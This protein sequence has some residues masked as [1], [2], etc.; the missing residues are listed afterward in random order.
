MQPADA[1]LKSVL[2]RYRN[3]SL[4]LNR[5]TS[6]DEWQKGEE[7][8]TKTKTALSLHFYEPIKGKL[9]ENVPLW[10]YLKGLSPLPIIRYGEEENLPLLPTQFVVTHLENHLKNEEWEAWNEKE[11][12]EFVEIGTI[13]SRILK[14]SNTFKITNKLRNVW[15]EL[16][17]KEFEFIKDLR[18]R[19]VNVQTTH[20]NKCYTEFIDNIRNIHDIHVQFL[21][22][23]NDR[24]NNV[25]TLGYDDTIVDFFVAFLQVLL[26]NVLTEEN[27]AIY[28]QFNLCYKDFDLSG[29][30][31]KML[32]KM[33]GHLNPFI[34]I[35]QHLQRY[36]LHMQ[37]FLDEDK[38]KW[39]ENI[40]CNAKSSSD[41]LMAMKVIKERINK[42]DPEPQDG[43]VPPSCV[44]KIR[45]PKF[46]IPQLLH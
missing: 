12:K 44:C 16:I 8:H 36:T 32:P 31:A 20:K 23:L 5:E 2:T 15:N 14:E 13:N 7:W 46:A 28:Q 4:F 22:S 11:W 18:N 34:V 19:V 39:N 25:Y 38:E 29:N 24:L 26:D 10:D 17:Q 41:I 37:V 3:A 40:R 42:L 1:F 6:N 33:Q 43:K 35:L 27:F 9:K 21:E 30:L 45:R